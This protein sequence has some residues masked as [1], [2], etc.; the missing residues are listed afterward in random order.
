MPLNPRAFEPPLY[1]AAEDIR[2]GTFLLRSGMEAGNTYY[3]R[4]ERI[5]PSAIGLPG[6]MVLIP[7]SWPHQQIG[8]A[9]AGDSFLGPGAD[10]EEARPIPVED[11]RV[12][13]YLQ[14]CE[15]R[16]PMASPLL[17]TLVAARFEKVTSIGL[18][19]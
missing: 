17:N 2:P 5:E 8:V 18:G 1:C 19:P 10:R 3:E 13:M 12:G 4:I 16:T 6:G 14:I 11:V 9:S 15:G 7:D